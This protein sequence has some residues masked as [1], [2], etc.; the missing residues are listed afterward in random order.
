MQRESIK[1]ACFSSPVAVFDNQALQ[2]GI[3]EG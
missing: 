1:A 3:S 2:S